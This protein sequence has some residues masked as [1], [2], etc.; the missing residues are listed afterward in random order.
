[1]KFQSLMGTP[2]PRP[3]D[4]TGPCLRPGGGGAQGQPGEP[5]E[6]VVGL[7]DR[8]AGR[9]EAAGPAGQGGEDD[10]SFQAGDELPHADVDAGAE[11]DVARRPAADVVA[12][13]VVAP[14]AGVPVGGPD[15]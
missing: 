14:A 1:M 7:G 15:E 8:L 3:V 13:G 11:G 4:G 5:L 9:L 12:V 2:V 10:L 6:G